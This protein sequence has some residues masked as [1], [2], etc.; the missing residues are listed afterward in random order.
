MLFGLLRTLRVT[1]IQSL[2][3]KL[4]AF[5]ITTV[6]GWLT[7]CKLACITA[8]EPLT[9]P[10]A[11]TRILA[12]QSAP[13][14]APA[15]QNSYQTNGPNRYSNGADVVQSSWAPIQKVTDHAWQLNNPLCLKIDE[16]STIYEDYR[17]VI[18]SPRDS[19]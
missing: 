4:A 17:H 2:A 12:S 18:V 13:F 10:Y 5:T 19:R 16:C 1:Y 9:V 3:S 6:K 8:S 14:L 15:T 7:N 11:Q